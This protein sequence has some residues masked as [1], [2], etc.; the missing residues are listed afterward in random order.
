MAQDA[1]EENRHLTDVLR[2]LDALMQRN[3]AGTATDNLI[4]KPP[5]FVI[6]PPPGES[7]EGE[8]AQESAMASPDEDL[9]LLTEVYR[10]GMPPPAARVR[11][12]VDAQEALQTLLPTL[13]EALDSAIT[14]ETTRLRER[15]AACLEQQLRE[16]LQKRP[17]SRLPTDQT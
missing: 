13:L 15:L 7:W 2:R 11:E 3:E 10:E 12:G 1:S 6:L 9:P 8:P 14:E 5:A 16:L 4:S 17:P